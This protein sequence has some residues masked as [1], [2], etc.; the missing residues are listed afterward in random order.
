MCVFLTARLSSAH[1]P[2][3]SLVFSL[4]FCLPLGHQA[5]DGVMPRGPA[6]PE[7][8][9]QEFSWGLDGSSV[10]LAVPGPGPVSPA[11]TRGS[12]LQASVGLAESISVRLCGGVQTAGALSASS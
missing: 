7:M 12:T 4:S 8:L 9:P 10:G 1:F 2:F 5:I 6:G 3:E 11:P